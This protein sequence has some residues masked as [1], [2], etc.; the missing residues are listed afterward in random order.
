MREQ[1][2]LAIIAIKELEAQ[3]GFTEDAGDDGDDGALGS[4]SPGILVLSL[5]RAPVLT[6]QLVLIWLL[7]E[8]LPVW[9]TFP[10][11]LSSHARV[12]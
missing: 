1:R 7:T 11:N 2:I 6:P 12:Q 4:T 10:L 9:P 8:S 5:S 3:A